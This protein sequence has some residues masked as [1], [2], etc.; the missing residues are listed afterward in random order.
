MLW[1]PF[2]LLAS[3]S[4]AGARVANEY[5]RMP[6]LQLA[7]GN[8]VMVALYSLPFVLFVHWPTDPLFYLFLVIQ[9]PLTIYQDKMNF[10][11]TAEY[12]GGIVSRNE[13]L[14]VAVL[15]IVWLIISPSLLAKSLADPLRFAATIAAL[16]F[17]IWCAMR[18]RRC[19]VSHA[20][21]KKMIP[22]VFAS[23]GVSLLG[24]A[25]ADHAAGDSAVFVYAFVQALIM[26]AMGAAYNARTQAAAL[27]GLMNA[28]AIRRIALLAL[29]TTVTPLA[30]V[31]GFRHVDNPAY[32]NALILLAPLWVVL[33]YKVVGR[34]EKADV[35]SGA[36]IVCGSIALTL[37]AA[38]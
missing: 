24:K 35:V 38:H 27:G 34:K 18:M 16:A 33:F 25:C 15:F 12:G 19:A 31:A 29:V 8:K 14:S 28:T 26:V 1:I 10:D 22:L 13:P 23:T 36:G 4:R 9:A 5:I 17:T 2:A 20:A 3:F 32:V 21:L 7:V 37:L 6:G 30:R 11:L